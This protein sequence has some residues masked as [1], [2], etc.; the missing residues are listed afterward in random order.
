M[1]MALHVPLPEAAVRSG[2]GLVLPPAQRPN[3]EGRQSRTANLCI[4]GE[5]AVGVFYDAAH[6]S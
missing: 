3:P 2:R 5:A 6:R 1:A 4:V